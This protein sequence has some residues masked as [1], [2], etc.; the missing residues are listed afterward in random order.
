MQANVGWKSKTDPQLL[1][2]AANFPGYELTISGDDD[3]SPCDIAL[4]DARF[5]P[6]QDQFEAALLAAGALPKLMIVDLLCITKLLFRLFRKCRFVSLS[7]FMFQGLVNRPNEIMDIG[8]MS[9]LNS[10]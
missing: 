9:S 7:V 4:I 6:T 1:L 8:Y 5:F 3:K 10:F 2:D